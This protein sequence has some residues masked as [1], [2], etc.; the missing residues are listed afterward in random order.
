MRRLEG[1]PGPR[2][3]HAWLAVGRDQ[4]PR[5]LLADRQ[6]L[7]PDPEGAVRDDGPERSRAPAI[8]REPDEALVGP[9][10]D[11]L[12][13][14]DAGRPG[15][16]HRCVPDRARGHQ[17]VGLDVAFLAAELVDRRDVHHGVPGRAV[18]GVERRGS[19]PCGSHPVVDAPRLEGR[20]QVGVGEAR[21]QDATR[22]ER[23]ARRIGT[24]RLGSVLDDPRCQPS[25]HGQEDRLGPV[26]FV[27]YRAP[28]SWP[29]ASLE[30]GERPGQVPSGPGVSVTSE[31][32][33]QVPDRGVVAWP[34]VE[35]PARGA[36]RNGDGAISAPS[37]ISFVQDLPG[38][39]TDL[40]GLRAYDSN[41]DG[42]GD[43]QG[44]ESKLDYLKGL[45]VGSVYLSN[46]YKSPMQGGG[47]DVAYHKEV[48]PN[49][50][51]M[52][53]FDNLL[54]N[55]H[56]NDMKVIMDFIPNL[57]KHQ[58][59]LDL[60]NEAVVNK[61]ID[62]LQFWVDKGVDGFRI[63]SV[64]PYFDSEDPQ[65]PGS[66]EAIDLL[67]MFRAVLDEA[68]KDNPTEPRYKK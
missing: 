8:V 40:E 51:T 58:P 22:D 20:V 16:C 43:L 33:G 41:G 55:I 12:L 53:D 48:D 67:K 47:D 66:V 32:D 42:I 3:T 38:A 23:E 52:E 29:R 34:L 24:L 57:Y 30:G 62:I 25:G 46:I 6:P 60:R 61:L 59:N 35:G 18:P 65:N 7:V 28:C 49:F 2:S 63:D 14:V 68:S 64:A 9:H 13:R 4:G 21:N 15:A 1:G 54:E 10:L 56:A 5:H 19:G 11:D 36:D 31:V 45:G 50:G 26:G 39:Q 44:V 27:E 17:A 37:E